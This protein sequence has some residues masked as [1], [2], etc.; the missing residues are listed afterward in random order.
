[1]DNRMKVNIQT[2]AVIIGY[3]LAGMMGFYSTIIFLLFPILNL[4]MRY[5]LAKI[6]QNIVGHIRLQTIVSILIF[7]TT[8]SIEQT[9]LYW[10]FIVVS[11]YL[12]DYFDRRDVVL[13]YAIMYTAVSII[14]LF[15]VYIAAMK[16]MG[17]DYIGEYIQLLNVYEMAMLQEMEQLIALNPNQ[18]TQIELFKTAITIQTNLVKLLYPVIFLIMGIIGTLVHVIGFYLVS[19]GAKLKRRSLGELIHFKYSMKIMLL[20]VFSL[21][22]MTIESNQAFILSWNLC[23]FLILAL[24]VTGLI[25]SIVLVKEIQV[26]KVLKLIIIGMSIGVFCLIPNG[27]MLV[28]IA[29]TL[30]NLRKTEVV[31]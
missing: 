31:I 25:T 2:F 18:S 3:V 13:P 6:E 1:M 23:F 20:F 16:M 5:Y 29:D 15:Y 7:I 19:I 22:L 9:I 21:I 10:I 11:S 12:M 8:G 17:T 28:G 26:N 4:P 14:G 27:L 30:F 24:Q